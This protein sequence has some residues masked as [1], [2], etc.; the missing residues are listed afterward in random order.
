MYSHILQDNP[1][2]GTPSSV[3]E[4][5]LYTSGKHKWLIFKVRSGLILNSKIEY[6]FRKYCRITIRRPGME[7]L[8]LNV[9]LHNRFILL[10]DYNISLTETD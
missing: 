2:A 8:T 1:S 7:S 6:L 9:L 5:L 10:A 4:L 3:T